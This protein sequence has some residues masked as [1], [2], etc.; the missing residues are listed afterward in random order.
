MKICVSAMGG[1]MEAKVSERFGRAPY[2][3]IVESENM[4]FT[5]VAN[6]AVSMQG[7]A[8]PEAVRQVA[9]QGAQVVLTGDL[10][11]N[12][13]TAIEA[14]GIK[15]VTGISGVKTVRQAVEEYLKK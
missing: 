2:F 15:G 12:A 10:G 5:P 7:G 13:K 1:S 9:A 4:K 6:N 3:V 8:G 11:P 14:A